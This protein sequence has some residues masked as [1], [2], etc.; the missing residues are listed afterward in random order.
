MDSSLRLAVYRAFVE[1][2]RAPSAAELAVAL[3]R[4]LAAVEA[5]L[6]E[7]DRQHALVLQPG[8]MRLLMAMPFSAVPTAFRVRSGGRGWWANC[9]WD[10]LGVPALLGA[11]AVI[12]TACADCGDPWR[13]EVRAGAAPAGAGLVHFAVPAASWWRDIVY[14]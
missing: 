8:T 2:E 9:A 13:L 10:A 4:P 11:D 14:T 3:G 5:E 12:E 1:E 7:L 6:R